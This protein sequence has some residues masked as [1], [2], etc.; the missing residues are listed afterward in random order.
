M[1]SPSFATTEL[2]MGTGVRYGI[3]SGLGD[4]IAK[5][6]SDKNK[7]FLEIITQNSYGS[8]Y[9][10]ELIDNDEV[11]IAITQNVIAH[12]AFHGLEPYESK[13]TNFRAIGRLYNEYIHI[14]VRASSGIKSIS[15]FKGKNISVGIY[16]SGNEFSSRKILNS[17]GLFYDDMY[18][19]FLTYADTIEQFREG[20]IDAFFVSLGMENETI[21][22]IVASE[23]AKFLSLD[24]AKTSNLVARFPQF[25]RAIIRA[26]TYEGQTRNIPALAVQALLIVHKDLPQDIVYNLTK[27][28]YENT[29][30]IAMGHSMANDINVE[31]AL[32][33]ITIPFH[34]GASRYFKEKGIIP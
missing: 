14:I 4:S 26:G 19:S 3:Y 23:G 24:D 27:T 33:G 10:I 18:V 13:R 6:V 20:R 2:K 17:Y 22:Y 21:K 34:E 11:D 16:A 32:D 9:N 29:A 25:T 30:E 7:G 31:N 28:I 12:Y 15:D 8:G 1:V 5:V